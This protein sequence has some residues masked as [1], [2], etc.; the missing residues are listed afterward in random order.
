MQQ[1]KDVA[2]VEGFFVGFFETFKD[3]IIVC[4]DTSLLSLPSPPFP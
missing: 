2:A 1:F 3:P 4:I